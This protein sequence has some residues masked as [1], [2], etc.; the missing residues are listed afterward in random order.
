MKKLL[1]IIFVAV[2][3]VGSG[4]VTYRVELPPP[5]DKTEAIALVKQGVPDEVIMRRIDDSHSVFYLSANEVVELRQAG[6]S[7]RLVTYMMYT[8][9]REAIEQ[10]HRAYQDP[11]FHGGIGVIYSH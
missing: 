5:V 7:D 8:R 3:V 4:C 2:A 6:L 1:S 10:T 9:T 11:Y